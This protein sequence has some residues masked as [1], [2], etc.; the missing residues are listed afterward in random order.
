VLASASAMPWALAAT[1]VGGASWVL[2]MTSLNVAMQLR[3]PESILGRCLSIH[4]AVTF[5]GMAAGAMAWG[6]V[7]DLIGLPGAVRLAA[8]WLAVT[9][10]LLHLL[11][12]MPTR[13]E[14]R[15]M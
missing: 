3:S 10:A 15:V 4:Q 12:P 7:A 5:G 2:A 8:L 14:G 11:A 6:L 1:F 9:M 13:E